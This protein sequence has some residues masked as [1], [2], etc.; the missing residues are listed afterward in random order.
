MKQEKVDQR[1]W[2]N[3]FKDGNNSYIW[4]V[5]RI[6]NDILNK[7]LNLVPY[8]DFRSVYNPHQLNK[9]L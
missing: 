7:K 8:T 4:R 6:Y 5:W 2:I 9:I 3:T 1:L